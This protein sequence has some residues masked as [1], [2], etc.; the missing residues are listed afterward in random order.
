MRLCFPQCFTDIDFGLLGS[1]A[2]LLFVLSASIL[3]GVGL[4]FE[5]VH[6]L[7]ISLLYIVSCHS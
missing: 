6:Y 1:F 4:L 2:L 7:L 3:N 5:C